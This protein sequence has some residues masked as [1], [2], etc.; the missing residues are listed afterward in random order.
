MGDA[1]A[2]WSDLQKLRPNRSHG[3]DLFY[4][5]LVDFL[6]LYNAEEL[7]IFSSF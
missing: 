4:A 6:K 7:H 2:Q 3:K 1:A 5:C